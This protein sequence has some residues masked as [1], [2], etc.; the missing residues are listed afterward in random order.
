MPIFKHRKLLS[1]TI[2]R[3]VEADRCIRRCSDD[4]SCACLGH[5]ILRIL[6]RH[7]HIDDVIGIG[8]RNVGVGPGRKKAP[9]LL[10]CG[11][12]RRCGWSDSQDR[13]VPL[14][15]TGHFK[16]AATGTQRVDDVRRVCIGIVQRYSDLLQQV[17]TIRIEQSQ[18]WQ[19][20]YVLE[21]IAGLIERASANRH[22]RRS[23][24][25]NDLN[26]LFQRLCAR[27]VFALTVIVKVGYRDE[28]RSRQALR[29]DVEVVVAHTLDR[30]RIRGC[31]SRSLQ[32]EAQLPQTTIEPREELQARRDWAVLRQIRIQSVVG[33]QSVAIGSR[34]ITQPD[35]CL[36]DLGTIN[37]AHGNATLLE[38][39]HRRSRARVIRL[40]ELQRVSAAVAQRWGVIHRLNE[41]SAP[42]FRHGLAIPNH[43]N[44]LAHRLGRVM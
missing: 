27:S 19:Q 6:R 21:T 2:K 40:D 43:E 16:E 33:T 30:T 39:R 20:R 42:D 9:E 18:L 5:C 32:R 14:V 26:A 15:H 11:R 1:L 10:N 3:K 7:T 31:V 28:D 13:L 8:P 22:H 12:A 36:A 35:D 25:R 23:V 34:C 29:I 4:E 38:Q 17:V 24:G 41:Q 37:V 44:E